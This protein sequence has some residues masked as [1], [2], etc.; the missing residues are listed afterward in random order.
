MGRVF[1]PRELPKLLLVLGILVLSEIC[2][3]QDASTLLLRLQRS[4][5][6]LNIDANAEHGQGMWGLT[7]GNPG[8]VWQYPNSLSFLVLYAA[9]KYVLTIIQQTTILNTKQKLPHGNHRPHY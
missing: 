5:A 8:D 2:A 1:N 4:R 3:C 7:Y 9:V 6:T